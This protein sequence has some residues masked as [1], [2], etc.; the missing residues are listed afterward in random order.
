MTATAIAPRSLLGIDDLSEDELHALL[1]LAAVMKR[2]PLAWRG[3]LEGRAVACVF[4]QASMR[5]Q[6]SLEVAAHRLGALP[7]VV[8]SHGDDIPD[9]ARSLSSYC[10]AIAVRTG[11]HRDLLEGAEHATVP[12]INAMTDREHP[13][14]A[15]ADCLALRERFGGLDGLQIAYVGAR[16]PGMHS[17]LEAAVLAGMTVR[18]AAP[19]DALPDP[20]LLAR[21]GAA[22]RLYA[23]PREATAGAAMVFT[24]GEPRPI[25]VAMNLLPV[26]Q[27]VL[28]VLVTGEWER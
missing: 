7:V 8:G 26:E 22:V 11:R 23:T 6:V 3:S 12:V 15:L 14:R 21:A 28:R 13:A 10:D 19:E 2:H 9:A 18:V 16:E 17:L 20:A 24:S 4:E 1:D 27:A 25:E 5:T